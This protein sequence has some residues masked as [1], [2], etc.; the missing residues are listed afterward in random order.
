MIVS[1]VAAVS[2]NRVIGRGGGLP[3]RL[4][5]DMAYF[6]RVTMGKPVVMGRKT[7]ES[8]PEK[9]RPL[10]GRRNVVISRSG[11]AE[12]QSSGGVEWVGSLAEA[13]ELLGGYEEVMV[14]GGGQV[15][16]EAMAA[17]G[18]LYLTEVG[19]DVD[20]DVFFPQY[21]AAVWREVSREHHVE[22]EWHYDWVVYER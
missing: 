9:F 18:R 21:D 7:W 3:W 4:K 6:Q 14:I 11:G 20:G 1:L 19:A 17:A 15:Y 13:F 10:A 8:I 12:G 5:D 2:A 22:G 16:A